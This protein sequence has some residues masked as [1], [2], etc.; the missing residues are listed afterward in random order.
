MAGEITIRGKRAAKGERMTG[1]A[2]WRLI[3]TK[4]RKRVF[5]GTLLNTYNFDKTRIAVFKVPK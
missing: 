2:G 3:T 5:N 1:G 4:G